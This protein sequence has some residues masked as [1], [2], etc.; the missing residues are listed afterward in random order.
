ME[1]EGTSENVGKVQKYR[2]GY[3]GYIHCASEKNKTPYNIL[4][5]GGICN[6]IFVANLV[7]SLAVKAF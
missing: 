5:Y 6:N 2:E 7:L 4:R 1:K 3:G